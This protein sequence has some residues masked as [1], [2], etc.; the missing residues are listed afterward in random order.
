MHEQSVLVTDLMNL[1][2]SEFTI[3]QERRKLRILELSRF[4]NFRQTIWDKIKQKVDQEFTH[5][6]NQF[7]PHFKDDNFEPILSIDN[8]TG[9]NIDRTHNLSLK[10]VKMHKRQLS[11]ATQVTQSSKGDTFYSETTDSILIGKSNQQSLVEMN[12]DV[13]VI[14][15]N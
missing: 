13:K 12:I 5:H 14:C 1:D 11:R 8:C 4:K 15:F 6:D 2:A 9:T 10:K 7:F 3:E